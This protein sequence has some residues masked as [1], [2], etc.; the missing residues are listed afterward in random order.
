MIKKIEAD[1]FAGYFHLGP[2]WADLK[3]LGY[4]PRKESKRRRSE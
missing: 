4:D 1:R 2:K 3:A